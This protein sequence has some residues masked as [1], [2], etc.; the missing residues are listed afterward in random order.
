MQ[1]DDVTVDNDYDLYAMGSCCCVVVYVSNRVGPGLLQ[2]DAKA[3]GEEPTQKVENASISSGSLHRIRNPH[4]TA[5][6]EAR[7]ARQNA[8]I[9]LALRGTA[10]RISPFGRFL[11]EKTRRTYLPVLCGRL[12]PWLLEN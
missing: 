8:K 12:V 1:A 7:I 6:A 4:T 3:V 5:P 11:T 2:Y 9:V 10:K